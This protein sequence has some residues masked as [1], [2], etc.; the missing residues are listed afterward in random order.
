MSDSQTVPGRM[1]ALRS[2]AWLWPPTTQP[3]SAAV[4]SEE[5]TSPAATR[6]RTAPVTR[7]KRERFRRTP[8]R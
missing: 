1:T 4:C 2:S 5:A 8:P 6:T 7:K 3:A